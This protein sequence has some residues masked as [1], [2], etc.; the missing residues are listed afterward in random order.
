VTLVAAATNAK[1][2]WYVTRGTGVVALL[3]LTAS[4][5]LGVLTSA[6]WRPAR[7]PRFLVG[8]LHRNLSLLGIAFVVVHVVTTIADRFAPIGFRDAVLPFLSPYRPVWLGLGTVTFDLMLALVFTSLLRARLGFR[9]WRAV[10]WLAYATWPI[11]LLHAFGTGS[12]ARF[13]WFTATL[14]ATCVVVVA[15]LLPR[16]SR[17]RVA[18]S[19]QRTAALAAVT[20]AV[21]VAVFIWYESGPAQT[22]WAARAGTPASL[23]R[24][25]TVARATPIAAQ[26]GRGQWPPR[27]FSEPLS[28]T[29]T[30]RNTASGL[31]RID[32]R[33][34]IRG[35]L[36][37]KLRITLWGQPSGEGVALEASD[38]AF[39]ASGT[40]GA[41]VGRVVTLAGDRVDARLAD[42]AGNRIELQAQLQVDRA[43]RGIKGVLRG[44]T[45]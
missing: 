12:D 9:S 21:P 39:A 20:L 44:R 19:P 42:G 28:G 27:T 37:G 11:A 8:G 16:L 36:R 22:G 5:V 15:S 24:R 45:A 1:T 30:E 17:S 23:L 38:V 40:S 18:A 34:H 6:R 43:T 29:L 7:T 14:F 4:L 41:Y 2:L 13:G 3:L 32:I 35:L 26:V 10:H 33:A 31:V 25:H